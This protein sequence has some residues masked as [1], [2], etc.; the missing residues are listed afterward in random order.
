MRS[1]AI[2]AACAASLFLIS[3][4]ARAAGPAAGSSEEVDLL[5]KLL[6]AYGV[7]GHEAGVRDAV[8]AEF[9]DWAKKSAKT[10]AMGNL[11]VTV[12]SGAPSVLYVAHMDE[13]GYVVT[14]IREDGMIQVQKFGGFY[15][16]QYEGQVVLIHTAAAGDVSGVV[17]MPSTHLRRD[18]ADKPADFTVDN[19]LID[20]GTPSRKETEALGIAL[21]DPIT[22]RKS[23][24]KLAGTRL[25]ARSMDDRF[26]CAAILA[27]VRRLKPADVK[28]TVTF[29]WSVQEEVGLRGAEAIAHGV[30]PDVV[31]AVDSFVTS[32][33]PIESKR[34]AFAPIGAGPMIRALDTSYI[35]P[36]ASVR[37]LMQFAKGKG[38]AL[39]YGATMGGNDGSVFHDPKSK[40]VPLSI[41]I[42]YSHSAIETID[43]R[44]QVGLVNLIDAMVRETSWIQ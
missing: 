31:I 12:G 36:I 33:S 34:L 29:A 25:A 1:R 27:V 7:S 40:V 35:A 23:V 11:T 14:N 37:A 41:P 43:T 8:L 42:R 18:A 39:G 10:D 6:L 15:D 32:D 13:I 17:V 19:I 44:D 4:P 28:G 3:P 30:S 9:P 21:L 22:I 5:T 38:L 24:T 16:W 26:G 20:T 2:A